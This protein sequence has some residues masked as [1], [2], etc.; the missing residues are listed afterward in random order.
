MKII[1]KTPE[2]NITLGLP[3][4]LIFSKGSAFLAEKL[5]RKYAPESMVDIPP[6]AIP[7]LCA[8]LRKIKKKYGTYELLELETANGQYVKITL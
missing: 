3:T 7:I 5:G 4:V 8:E 1:V 6:D 2:H